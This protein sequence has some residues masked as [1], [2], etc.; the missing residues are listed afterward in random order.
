[1]VSVYS[2]KPGERSRDDISPSRED[3]YARESCFHP[4]ISFFFYPVSS[5]P[6]RIFL[7][8]WLTSSVTKSLGFDLSN[9]SQ[10]HHYPIIFLTVR[11][12]GRSTRGSI[13]VASQVRLWKLPHD[14]LRRAPLLL[15]ASSSRSLAYRYSLYRRTAD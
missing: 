14:W 4:P 6:V 2:A 11:A 10:R 8:P 7:L 12:C 5:P 15:R 1:M 3:T 13:S 9:Q